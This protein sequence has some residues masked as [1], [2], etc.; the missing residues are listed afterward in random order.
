MGETQAS[1]PGLEEKVAILDAGAQY[2]K[3]I[4]RKVRHLNVESEVLPL[5]T[6]T[7]ELEKYKA[8]IISGGPGSVYNGDAPKHNPD[9]FS[10]GKPV[11]GI[12]YGMQLMSHEAGGK[13][14]KKPARQD[15]QFTIKVNGGPFKRKGKLFEGL[16]RKLDVLMSH[17]DSILKPGKGFKVTAKSDGIVAAI[18]N[19]RK[20]QYGVQFHP[21]VDLTPKGQDMLRTFLYDVS[22]FEGEYTIEDRI[23]K[24]TQE[25]KEAAGDKK[26]L[27]L[28]SG[29]VDSAV[30]T[31]LLGE[32]LGPENVYAVHI[33]NGLMREGESEQVKEALEQAGIKL[34]VYDESERFYNAT[35]T[36][37]GKRTRKLDETNDPEEKRKIIGDTFMRS[38]DRIMRELGLDPKETYLAQGT[39]RPD[40]I[41]SASKLAS[42]NADTIKTHHNDTNLV[43]QLRAEGR[44]IEPLKDYHKDE[45]REVGR[46]LGLPPSIVERQ[47]F[48]GPGLGVRVLCADEPYH[49]SE[50]LEA[51]VD[52][53]STKDIKATVL[54]VRTVGVQGDGRTYTHLVGLSGAEDWDELFRIARY[55]P[56]NVRGA[57]RV[58]YVFGDKVEEQVTDVTPTH[59]TPDALS[60]LRQADAIVNET[61]DKYQLNKKPDQ[62][63][64]VSFPVGFGQDSYRS[65]GIRTIITNDWMTGRAAKPG[66]DIPVEAVHEM[67]GRIQDEVP[68]VARVAYDLTSKP[69]GTT[70]WE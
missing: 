65:I 58:A 69:P 46:Q 44:V 32:A 24:A 4:D 20:K 55:L 3:V 50:D 22:G 33:D 47:P 54:P 25:V 56:T 16:G 66:E 45:V 26:V 19:S 70:E 28:I 59:L 53:Y 29:G 35:T 6:P 11:L 49:A 14:G 13:V 21:E 38:A 39:L 10:L 52:A 60:Q 34:H 9:T 36:I 23:A 64:V 2:G 27:S 31:T 67:V 63:P 61:L 37:D 1:R 5:D 17:G 51:A 40:L 18:E 7:E 8:L 12:C 41:E 68:G 42:G 62:V 43:R 30:C 15:G 48:P 57:N